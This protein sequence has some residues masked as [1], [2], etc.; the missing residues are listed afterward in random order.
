[1]KRIILCF[2][3]VLSS[4]FKAQIRFEKGYIITKNGDKKEVLIKNIDWMSS[5]EEFTYKTDESSSEQNGNPNNIEEFG[6]YG[7]NSYINYT[8][9]IDISSE[10]LSS[11][12]FKKEPELKQVQVFLKRLANGNKKLYSYRSKNVLNYFYSDSDNPNNIK[13]LI[14]KKYHPQNNNLLVATNEEYKQ[15]L[16]VL[17]SDEQNVK[18]DIS[19]AKYS[20]NDLIKV[21]GGSMQSNYA[22]KSEQNDKNF[23]KTKF[24]LNVRPGF[25][26]YSE[27]KIV[28]FM[29]EQRLPSTSNFRIGVEAEVFLPFNKNKWSVILEPNYSVYTSKTTKTPSSNI[30]Y[31]HY[32]NIDKYSFIDIPLGVRYY[33]FLNEKS[34]LFVNGQINL[35]KIKSTSTTSIDI[36]DGEYTVLT[37]EL[38]DSRP[39]NSFALGAGY[40]YNNKFSFELRY[41]TPGELLKSEDRRGAT[42]QYVSVILGYNLF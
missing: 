2:V 41:N 34:K 4:I 8:G 14:Y 30:N 17:F 5:P 28:N 19:K 20:D 27:A 22:G 12:S 18:S 38:A 36:K 15:Q 39:F 10:E 13:L 31:N 37:A 1:M 7:Y 23:R 35:I 3:I 40:N 33:M 24:N 11:L 26:F 21:F 6:V 42:L 32:V 16:N 9:P 25:N 29:G